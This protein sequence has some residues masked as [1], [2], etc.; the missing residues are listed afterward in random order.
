MFLENGLK[1]G[2]LAAAVV[3]ILGPACY[4][5]QTINWGT[6]ADSLRA[7]NGQQITYVC[8]GG[9]SISSRVWGTN[10]Y[11]D[12]S[13]ICSAAVHAGYIEAAS[14]GTVTIEIRAGQASYQGVTR[15]GVTSKAFGSWP[16]SF[17]F[18]GHVSGSSSINWAA[19][20][21]SLRGRT[22]QRFTFRC[23]GGG[24]SSGRLWGT[25][26]YTDDSSICTAGV[27]AGVI[28]LAGGG[29]VTIEIRAGANSYRSSRRNGIDSRAYGSYAGSFVVVGASATTN[30]AQQ[31]NWSTDATSLRGRTGQRFT[32][33]CPAGSLSGRIWGTD[34][35][36]DDSSICTAAVHAGLIGLSGGTVTI[37]IRPSQASYQS[38]TRNGVRANG[39]GG[40]N[41]SFVF[42]R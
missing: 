39:F 20:A 33:S 16:G 21:D 3:F 23:P 29:S 1:F 8:P 12:D 35:Y 25:D 17:V 15:N 37:E 26:L 2:V 5:Q 13:S 36:T 9:G 38:S 41:G 24:P 19:Q 6:Q 7:R 22:G 27:H 10:I 30:Q 18:V 28:S 40:W 11:T 4:A 34:V 14:G 42:V 32:F 31:I